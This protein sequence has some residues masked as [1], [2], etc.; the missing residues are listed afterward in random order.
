MIRKIC[1]S[2]KATETP[3][4]MRIVDDGV[5]MVKYLS[6]LMKEKVILRIFTD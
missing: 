1:T 3:G 4:V 2:P 5:N 6:I